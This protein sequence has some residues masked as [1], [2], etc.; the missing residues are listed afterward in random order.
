MGKGKPL[1][2]QQT[3]LNAHI[4]TYVFVHANIYL[5]ICV[6]VCVII[7]IYVCASGKEGRKNK[8]KIIPLLP[9]FFWL[10]SLSSII[11]PKHIDPC[12][13]GRGCG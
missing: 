2:E 6:C 7:C 11:S 4:C 3:V 9:P 10:L 8:Q 12:I 1:D 5:Y 13:P